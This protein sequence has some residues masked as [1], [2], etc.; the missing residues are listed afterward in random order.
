MNIILPL[1]GIGSRFLKDGYVRPKPFIRAN[2]KEI[3]VLLLEKL[4]TSEEDLLVL[5]Y[6][7]NPEAG[8]SPKNFFRIIMISQHSRENFKF[9]DACYISLNFE[10]VILEHFAPVPALREIP[11]SCWRS[12]YE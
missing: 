4:S 3:I 7:E 1:A 11:D 5:V 9:P 6:N 12:T 8:M 10:S 2:G